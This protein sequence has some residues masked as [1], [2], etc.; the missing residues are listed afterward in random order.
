MKNKF[1][2]F[3][4]TLFFPLICFANSESIFL[5]E[6]I[7]EGN[8]SFES[9]KKS[10]FNTVITREEI[11]RRGYVSL[12]NILEKEN[13][14]S[15]RSDSGSNKFSVLDLR[16]MGEASGSNVL[17]IVDDEIINSSDMSGA[18]LNDIPAHLIDSVEIIRGS[19]AVLNGS[20]AV[21]G[22]IKI[23]T[24]EPK[25]NKA[26]LNLNYGSYKTSEKSIFLSHKDKLQS[27]SLS[28]DF[29]DSDGYRENSFYERANALV[30]YENNY[31]D[32]IR[33]GLNG[34]V[35]KDSYGLPGGITIEN[36][37]D[38]KRKKTDFPFDNGSTHKKKIGFNFEKDFFKYGSLNISRTYSYKD[39]DY[40]MGYSHLIDEEDQLNS[41]S[42]VSKDLRVSYDFSKGDFS[43]VSGFD[44]FFDDYVRTS[45]TEKLR[46]NGQLDSKDI[47]LS[48]FLKK[49]KI[50]INF[51][52]RYSD[53]SSKFREDAL[54]NNTGIK[55]DVLKENYNN[56]A[57]ELG[58]TYLPFEIPFEFFTV[59]S[60]S[61][62]NPNIDELGFSSG[63]LSPQ[64]SCN[65]EAG[66]R[67][68]SKSFLKAE[69]SW[70]YL[71]TNDEIYYGEDGS[72]GK[73]NKNYE[74][75]TLRKGIDLNLKFNIL[76]NLFASTGISFIKAEFG[77]SGEEI[78]L[79]S[80]FK[81]FAFIEYE[82]FENF[83]ATIDYSYF[84]S[85][86][87]GSDIAGKLAEIPSYDTAD[88]SVRYKI[89]YLSFFLKI[90]NI[91]NEKYYTSAYENTC[92][93]MAE[94]NFISGIKAEF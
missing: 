33:L 78:P 93:P 67:F 27:F 62:R 38:E 57:I 26:V 92:Y 82:A 52:M 80:D 37:L 17:I 81:Y 83:F 1:L 49:K 74:D 50:K 30:K 29:Y 79:V 53:S 54:E 64:R 84:S 13:S 85:K 7:V 11:D 70:F 58:I 5:E 40:I 55:G 21:S 94:R 73:F 48:S 69:A 61:Y 12:F 35:L 72:G 16:G 88:I 25:K 56:N 39:N 89:K 43:F 18:D 8:G 15:I 24:I 4:L 22:V 9:E 75:S 6:I 65:Y 68:F 42:T 71:K 34:F 77:N 31:L 41:I 91:F 14:V 63:S 47:Y 51:G 76:K 60:K 59:F 10:G 90:K 32:S 45:Q 86:N 66:L 44:W 36:A 19:G 46:K 28:S 87:Q 20:G 2:L 23:K 3:I